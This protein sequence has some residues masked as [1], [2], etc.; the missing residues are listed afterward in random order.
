MIGPWFIDWNNSAMCIPRKCVCKAALL[1]G[2]IDAITSTEKIETIVDR[3]AETIVE[4]NTTKKYKDNNGR[5][6]EEGNCQDFVDAILESL[7]LTADFNG[8][9]GEFLKKLRTKLYI[10]IYLRH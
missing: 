9:L 4:W 10:R 7:G 1:S 8:P 6:G 5:K 2:D 3:L